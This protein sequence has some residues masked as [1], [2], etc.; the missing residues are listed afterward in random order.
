MVIHY[1]IKNLRGNSEATLTVFN[2]ALMICV[3]CTRSAYFFHFFHSL[4][5]L[6]I[7][8]ITHVCVNIS[9]GV[10]FFSA[11]DIDDLNEQLRGDR[12][13]IQQVIEMIYML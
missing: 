4:E 8:S 13:Q 11:T 3:L 6:S 10:I 5:N 12:Q 7:R 2:G 1:I 9:K